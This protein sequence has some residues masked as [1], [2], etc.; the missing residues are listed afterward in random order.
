MRPAFFP[1]AAAIRE[2]LASADISLATATSG[3]YRHLGDWALAVLL[4]ASATEH[5]LFQPDPGS[6]LFP[7]VSSAAVTLLDEAI[8]DSSS[9]AAM[10]IR[11]FATVLAARERWGL[12][13]ELA[14]AFLQLSVST[15]PGLRPVLCTPPR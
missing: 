6:Y 7:Q 13:D 2:C 10:A 4:T 8:G 11:T 5:G 9:A 3:L 14:S 12:L 1:S 15:V